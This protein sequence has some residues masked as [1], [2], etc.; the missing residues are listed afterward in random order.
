MATCYVM[1]INTLVS[2]QLSL[3][4]SFYKD[5]VDCYFILVK[6]DA[7]IIHLSSYRFGTYSELNLTVC[8]KRQEK[9]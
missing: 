2:V 4:L 6:K 3:S 9:A 7:I 8:R 5:V 1:G